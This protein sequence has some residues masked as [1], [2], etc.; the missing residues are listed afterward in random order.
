MSTLQYVFL[1]LVMLTVALEAKEI[2]RAQEGAPTTGR[3]VVSLDLDT[4]TERF[5]DLAAKIRIE[6]GNQNIHKV[7]GR[8]AKIITANL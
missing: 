2:L 6:A 4:S 7:D 1:S 5:E 3:F 8:Y